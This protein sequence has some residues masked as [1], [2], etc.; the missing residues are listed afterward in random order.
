MISDALAAWQAQHA[1][2]GVLALLPEAEKDHLGVLQE[3]CRARSVP[4]VGGIFPALVS[5]EGFA[6]QG[7]WLLR[8]DHMVP[9]F[10]LPD[11][12]QNPLDAAAQIAQAVEAALPQG[13]GPK[14][15]LY[16]LLD[17]LLPHIASIVDA[18]YLRL[19]DQVDYAGVN[20]GSESF[21]PMPCLFD[22]DRVVGNAVLGLLL[23]G[24]ESTVLAHGY[25]VPERVMTATSTE[26]NRILHIDWQ[27]AFDAYQ[28]I[29][30][31]EYGIALTRD[32]F[33][34]YAVHFPFGI[35]RASND[36]VVRIPVALG[37]DGSL[38]CVGEVPENAMLVLL[39]APPAD[40][41]HC[42]EHLAAALDQQN[43]A[44]HGRSLLAFYCAG[45]RMHMGHDADTELLALH[46]VSGVA[47][48]AGAL[49]LGEIGSTT[50]A[51]Y[52]LFHNAALVCTPWPRA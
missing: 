29:I 18:L 48:M 17:G 44:M 36:V 6:T 27:P 15:T 49:S 16:L 1:Q 42:I 25:L 39:R 9:S 12:H 3:A 2:M 31:A 7:V 52:P 21:Q 4:L 41:G 47:Q 37:E 23:P 13:P 30:Q 28:A 35:M 50:L 43:G 5:A 46:R 19:A 10:L 45:R 20:A 26:G 8:L 32:N 14:P 24:H 38:I 33:Y 40:A 51:G 34:Q 22:Q 11:I